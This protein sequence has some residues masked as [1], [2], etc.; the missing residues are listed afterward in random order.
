MNHIDRIILDRACHPAFD[1]SLWSSLYQANPM[2]SDASSA[3]IFTRLWE[4][5]KN[6]LFLNTSV[7]WNDTVPA[8]HGWQS[9]W[10]W[11]RARQFTLIELERR[12][13]TPT[14]S[15]D[16]I[17]EPRRLLR[18]YSRRTGTKIVRVSQLRYLKQTI[19][20]KIRFNAASCYEADDLLA[21]QKD[22]EITRQTFFSGSLATAA[23]ET[24]ERLP[25]R[26]E[27]R[28]SVSRTYRKGMQSIVRPYWLLCFSTELDSRLLREFH[29]GT[30]YE[31]G[32]LILFDVETFHRRVAEA[33]ESLHLQCGRV[34]VDYYD[35]HFPPNWRDDQI[36]IMGQKPFR[37]AHQ[38]ELRF[39]L[40]PEKYEE[41]SPP[42]VI[43]FHTKAMND[44]AGVYDSLGEKVAGVGPKRLFLRK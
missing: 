10:W 29:D 11:F 3:D 27:I 7:S 36:N 24:G 19:E 2:L 37:F 26:G 21:S 28:L 44:I 4:I 15:E 42:S 8:E 22:D 9:P 34:E 16:N 30:E 1:V 13:I 12:G 39:I 32:I 38:R 6:I 20:G 41:S 33:I 14:R 18:D 25:L 23:G 17:S 5:E 31:Q 40:L 35:E 43:S